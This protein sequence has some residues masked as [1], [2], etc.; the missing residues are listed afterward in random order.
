MINLDNDSHRFELVLWHRDV[1]GNPIRK[2]YLTADSGG[3]LYDKF[4]KN[5]SIKKKKQFTKA[6]TDYKA[7]K[8]L[9]QMYGD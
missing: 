6:T 4:M 8:I 2:K 7:S 9:K 1:N 5:R 3:E